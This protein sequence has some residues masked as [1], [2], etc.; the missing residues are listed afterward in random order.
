MDT[1][2]IVKQIINVILPIGL[3]DQFLDRKQ[4]LILT[5]L[6]K[7]AYHSR[8]RGQLI[9]KAEINNPNCPWKSEMWILWH[10]ISDDRRTELWLD[11]N[12]LS[13]DIRAFIWYTNPDKLMKLPNAVNR[14][15]DS[16]RCLP[17][18]S[19]D[20]TNIWP[21]LYSGKAR[22]KLLQAFS[23][24]YIKQWNYQ[25]NAEILKTLEKVKRIDD[26]LTGIWSKLNIKEKRM[27]LYPIHPSDHDFIVF[28]D[29]LP[30]AAI[31]QIST[32]PDYSQGHHMNIEGPV[33]NIIRQYLKSKPSIHYQNMLEETVA[34]LSSVVESYW[35][36]NNSKNIWH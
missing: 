29:R 20:A 17:F 2:N 18:I 36:N 14:E 7:Q 28:W 13:W 8:A 30:D 19:I 22:L 23:P 32:P 34:G 24:S 11:I 25:Y 21:H 10:S 5:S 26:S 27:W 3:I 16:I 9:A 33:A 12:K 1:Y 35:L 6:N 15:F 31:G 4:A